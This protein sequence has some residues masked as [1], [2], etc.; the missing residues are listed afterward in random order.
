MF[1]TL[2]RVSTYCLTVLASQFVEAG[3]FGPTRTTMPVRVENFKV[4]VINVFSG[5]DIGDELQ[6]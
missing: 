3:Y 4:V 5:K 6:E 2:K 1:T